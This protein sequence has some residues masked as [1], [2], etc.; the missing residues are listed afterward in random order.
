MC[1]SRTYRLGPPN[2]LSQQRSLASFSSAN[3]SLSEYDFGVCGY[4]MLFD[5]RALV[6]HDPSDD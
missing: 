3:T 1:S 6:R 5:M 2:P 4:R